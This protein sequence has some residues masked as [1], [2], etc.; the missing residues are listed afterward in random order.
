[1]SALP[2]LRLCPMS[3][4][5][6]YNEGRMSTSL[7]AIFCKGNADLLQHICPK[8]I[9]KNNVEYFNKYGR[10]GSPFGNKMFNALHL[11][12]VQGQFIEG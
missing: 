12:G 11:Y 8:S 1:M 5:E 4:P 6:H 10:R 3:P 2:G 9:P 7:E